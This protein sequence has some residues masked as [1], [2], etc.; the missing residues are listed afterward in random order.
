MQR[1]LRKALFIASFVERFE[2]ITLGKPYLEI[3]PLLGTICLSIGFYWLH[4]DS[5]LGT[6]RSTK[7]AFHGSFRRAL[8][9]NYFNKKVP[10]ITFT[11]T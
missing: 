1:A 3:L 7:E 9:N 11:D 4:A 2:T 8:R 10:L 6:R 5:K